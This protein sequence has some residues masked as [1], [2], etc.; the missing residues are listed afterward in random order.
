MEKRHEIGTKQLK[1]E[2]HEILKGN[3]KEISA[4]HSKQLSD[5]SRNEKNNYDE[6]IQSIKK[7]KKSMEG[8]LSKKE[9]SKEKEEYQESL[10]KAQYEKDLTILKF[11]YELQIQEQNILKYFHLE[12]KQRELDLDY[13]FLVQEDEVNLLYLSNYYNSQAEFFNEHYQEKMDY[14]TQKHSME[15]EN[16][17][18]IEM[19]KS[20]KL[21]S[22]DQSFEYRQYKKE[23]SQQEKQFLKQQKEWKQKNKKV[24]EK[25]ILNE[26]LAKWKE[27]WI[28]EQEREEEIFLENQRAKREEE[29]KTLKKYYRKK[30]ENMIN[31]KEESLRILEERHS[32]EKTESQNK[33]NQEMKNLNWE[34]WMHM[35]SYTKKKQN[36]YREIKK[37]YSQ[38]MEEILLEWGETEIFT[39]FEE[40]HSSIV[41]LCENFH[42]ESEIDQLSEELSEYRDKLIEQ[43][44]NE[45]Q[46]LKNQHS[47]EINASKKQHKEERK[48]MKHSAPPAPE[49]KQSKGSPE[50][51]SQ[52]D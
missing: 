39:I 52:D 49:E 51:K 44:S 3:S 37:K 17:K 10:N 28:L 21:L 13:Y 11:E 6:K 8:N 23:K 18:E 41:R 45:L 43:H 47:E 14:L 5:F 31:N 42:Q 35:Y 36:K 22:R 2:I 29:E 27:E 19:E 16:L 34:R 40:Y 30:L 7:K 32:T 12:Q 26:H 33:H 24:L 15:S 25:S 38:E 1:K 9:K 20:K 46:N 50:K 48:S 4:I